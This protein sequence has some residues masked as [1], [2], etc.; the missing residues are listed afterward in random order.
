MTA[1]TTTGERLTGKVSDQALLFQYT[2]KLVL[3]VSFCELVLYRL[4]SRLGMHLSKLA[5]QHEWIIPTFTALTE[6]GQWLLNAV[7]ILLFLG[8]GV[9]LVNRSVGRRM[10]TFDKITV[11]STALLLLLTVSFLFVPPTMFGS[12]IYNVVALVTLVSLMAEY[13][14]THGERSHRAMGLT[15]LFGIG[16]WLYYQIVSTT[17]SFLGTVAGPPFVYE[18]HRFGEALMVLS[19]ILVFWAYGHG[20]SVRTRNQRQRRRAIWFWT[21]AISIFVFMLFLDYLLDQ[22]NSALASNIRNAARGIGWIFQF[23]MGYTF[24][25]PFAF[26]MAGLICWSYTVIKLLTMGRLAGYGI[27]LMFIAGYALLYSNLT[28]MVILG[29]MLLTM[30]RAK[31]ETAE[32][33]SASNA[34]MM[35]T[36]ESLV[37]GHI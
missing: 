1:L 11:P 13:L 15:Y 31:R 6:I 28:L 34:P 24:Y 29:V 19:S 7:A 20:V 22:Y 3:L 23:G 33:A 32:P 30:D 27:G 9:A 18:A 37:S 21:T 2:I 25:L 36:P 26:Y 8:L 17:Y 12:A 5:A 4:V 16:G 10:T 35:G 14:S